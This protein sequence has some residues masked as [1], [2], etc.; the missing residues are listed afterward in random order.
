MKRIAIYLFYDKQGVVDS[1]IEHMLTE[2]RHDVETIIVVSNSGITSEGRAKLEALADHVWRREN[3]GFDVWAYK[4]V[5][6]RVGYDKL[7]EY[8]E[9]LLMNYTFFGPIGSFSPMFEEM[10]AKNV[11]FWGITEHADYSPNPLTGHG[12]MPRHIQSHWIAVSKSLITAPEFKEYWDTMPM[13]KSY[14]DSIYFHESRFTKHF[15]DRGFISAT[16]F[17]A[18][19]YPAPH[20]VFDNAEL[21]LR[22]GCPILKRRIF[23]HDPLYLDQ[24][25]VLAGDLVRIA[26]DRGY[27]V[28]LIWEN[29]GRSTPPRVL[30][31]NTGGM[32]VFDPNGREAEFDAERRVLVVAHVYYA[33]MIDEILDAVESVPGSR[34]L[35]ITTADEERKQAIE[36]ALARRAVADAEVRIVESNRG[37]DV[38][39]FLVTCGDVLADEQFDYVVKLHSKKS[40]QDEFMVGKFFKQHLIENLLPTRAYTSQVLDLFERDERLGMVFPPVLHTGYPTMGHA[41]FVNKAGMNDL[42]DRMGLAPSIDQDTPLAP[43]GSMFVARRSVLQPLLDLK[44]S[45]SDFPDS[46]NY[47]DGTLAHIIERAYGYLPS[48]LGMHTQT[49]MSTERIGRD[50]T[51]L[52]YKYQLLAS[53]LPAWPAEQVAALKSGDA[54]EPFL[55]IVKQRAKTRFPNTAKNIRPVYGLLRS[56]KNRAR[57][58]LAK[59]KSQNKEGS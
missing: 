12:V 21:V 45:W 30:Q 51:M 16:A 48:A 3:V 42:F 52:E 4:D 40:A 59:R 2:L 35:V 38:G 39:A 26:E 33:D 25:A 20:P 41:W 50:Y 46:K 32:S 49:V 15:E 19:N 57:Q 8:D 18:A 37:R 1:Y 9:L 53:K 24:H 17:P 27:P 5:I 14:N 31:T 7:A 55:A 56:V 23:F 36:S 22:D 13:I 29:L 43:L 6:E 34:H 58:T 54:V 47:S 10:A 44:L 11:D 28:E